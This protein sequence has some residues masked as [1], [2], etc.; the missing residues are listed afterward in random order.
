MNETTSLTQDSQSDSTESDEEFVLTVE[1]VNE[2]AENSI[3]ELQETTEAGDLLK[4]PQGALIQFYEKLETLED[5]IDETQS[6]N[7]ELK[8]VVESLQNGQK[9]TDS[10]LNAICN[11]LDSAEELLDQLESSSEEKHTEFE[12]RL[13]MLE[14]STSVEESDTPSKQHGNSSRIE[15]ISTL[16][17]ETLNQQFSVNMVRAVTIYRFFEEWGTNTRAGTRLKSGELRKLLNAKLDDTDLEWTQ[18]HRAMKCF[19]KNTPDNY[20][21]IETQSVGKALIKK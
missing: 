16:D 1:P 12:K 20:E 10:R 13:T 21:I 8:E 9:I 4:I 19:D 6:E 5:K 2:Q 18:V 14:E 11:R 15:R 17:D 7:Q 3:S